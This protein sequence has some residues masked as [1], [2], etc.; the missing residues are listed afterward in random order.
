MQFSNGCWLFKEGCEC[1]SPREIYYTHI[2]EDKVTMN[3]PTYHVTSRGDTLGNVNLT[4][5][6]SCPYPEVI[7]IHTYHHMGLAKKGPDFELSQEVKGLMKV[8]ETEEELTIT[9]GKLSV[10][11]YKKTGAFSFFRDG[12]Y[13]T[14]SVYRDLAYLK[15][16][17]KGLAYDKGPADAYMKGALSRCGAL[18]RTTMR[19]RWA[20]SG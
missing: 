16:D 13:L 20:K 2:L 7:R 5:Q 11:F 19:Q 3:A 4:I 8:D 9:N 15:T 1:F 18:C 12:E 17:W 10:I 6:V 14:G